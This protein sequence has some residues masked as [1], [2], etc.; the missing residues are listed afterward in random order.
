[1]SSRAEQERLEVLRFNF[2]D[3]EDGFVCVRVGVVYGFGQL[4]SKDVLADA[5]GASLVEALL[6]IEDT[7]AEVEVKAGTPMEEI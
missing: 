1:M 7:E 5:A 3:N 2:F 6:G 4:S